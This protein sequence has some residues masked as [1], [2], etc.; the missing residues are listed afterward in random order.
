VALG[1]QR[2]QHAAQRGEPVEEADTAHA[3]GVVAGGGQAGDQ[4][5]ASKTQVPASVVSLPGKR[6]ANSRGCGPAVTGVGRNPAKN[7]WCAA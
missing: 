5:G 4:I 6:A 2:R 1:E 7:A 3:G